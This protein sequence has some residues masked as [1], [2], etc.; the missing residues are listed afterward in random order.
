MIMTVSSPDAMNPSRLFQL[1]TDPAWSHD[2]TLV[3]FS[4]LAHEYL[5]RFCEVNRNGLID[6]IEKEGVSEPASVLI[7]RISQ[8]LLN[9]W[10][11]ERDYRFLNLLFKFRAKRYLDQFP[12]SAA[13]IA[14]RAQID[15]TLRWE[16]CH[17]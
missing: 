5:L 15:Q 3:P 17:D 6:R 2:A 12:K 10:T 8:L 11:G 14:L 13:A 4:A 16:L 7:H 1:L 9:K